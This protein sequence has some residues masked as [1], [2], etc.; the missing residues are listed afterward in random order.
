M[1]KFALLLCALLVSAGA[2]LAGE[3]A[4]DKATS[5]G[6]KPAT[7]AADKTHVVEAEVVSADATAK[8]LTI[9]GTPENKTV[10]VEDAAASD[11]SALKAGDK[12]KLTCKDN[13][14]GEHQTVT[15]IEKPSK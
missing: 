11:L 8:T 3:K 5:A 7:A 9:K 4:A 14:A 15:K 1:K 6:D 12:V 13:A 10:K 2:A